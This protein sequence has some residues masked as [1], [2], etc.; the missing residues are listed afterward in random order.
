MD[1]IR[2]GR[3]RVDKNG[4]NAD[5][6]VEGK[7]REVFYGKSR[8]AFSY[9]VN[10][11]LTGLPDSLA[12]VPVIGFMLPIA[13]IYDAE[14]HVASLD[15]DFYD[16]IPDFKRGYIRMY[17]EI[18]FR[19]GVSVDRIEVNE[20]PKA[21]A[22][23]L[24]S[25]GVDATCTALDHAGE[26]PVLLTI[27]SAELRLA[28]E[29]TWRVVTR[30]NAEFARILGS[31]FIAVESNFRSILNS[32][33]LNTRTLKYGDTWWHGFQHGLAILTLTAPVTWQCGIATVYIASS[34]SAGARGRITCA[35]DPSIDNFVRFGGTRVVHDGYSLTRMDKLRDI[36]NWCRSS[37]KRV[38]LRA[39]SKTNDGRN[40]C[41]C[42]KCWRTM[43]GLYAVGED[44]TQYGFEYAD[45]GA[46]MREI[47]RGASGLLEHFN[48]RYIPI[49]KALR[50]NYTEETVSEDLRWL[51]NI[52][53]AED[54]EL[55]DW[56]NELC[57]ARRNEENEKKLILQRQP[58]RRLAA[59]WRRNKR[60]IRTM[61]KRLARRSPL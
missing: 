50:A 35:S 20:T 49:I 44:P 28:G 42:E 8:T 32:G 1:S 26:K 52:D 29:E 11:D 24:F 5:I 53:I 12:A 13:W 41:H 33:V 2:I 19:G 45:F 46:Q 21:G 51:W 55:F 16:S 43:L 6:T 10:V 40:C 58:R 56:I 4:I 27:R 3:I 37:G 15:R 60:R 47:H 48:T 17:P 18:D 36:A 57:I 14:I 39:C 22:L 9:S 30:R 59:F 31:R 25:G 7:V 54:S 23:C 38:Y 61:M 34:F